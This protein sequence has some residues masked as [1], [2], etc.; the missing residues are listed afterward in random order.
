[1]RNVNDVIKPVVESD[2]EIAAMLQHASIPTLMMSM[3][4][5]S[6]DA[7]ILDGTIRPGLAMLSEVQGY[8]SE[9]DKA[10]VRQQALE[11]IARYRD[12][13]CELPPPPSPETIQRM[14]AFI[15]GE[16]KIDDI[17]L[18]MMQE[19]MALSGRDDRDV[20]ISPEALV[21]R[22]D[23]FHVVVAGGGMSGIL[24][25]V[26]LAQSGIPFTILEKNPDV[27]GTWYENHYPG[28]R[29]DI[30]NHLYSYSFEPGYEWPKFFAER[31]HLLRYFQR[32]AKKHGVSERIRFNSE[33]VSAVYDEDGGKWLVEYDCD[34]EKKELSGDVFVSAVGQL[35][36]PKIPQVKG[37]DAFEGRQCHSAQWDSSLDFAGKNVALVGSG[38]SAFQLA[39]ELAKL[40]CQL[41]VF[42]RT[43]PWMLPN[44]QYHD[45]IAEGKQW[46]LT[47]LP[48]YQR[49]YR[50]LLFWPGADG[51]YPTIHI[52]PDWEDNG[53]SINAANKMLRDMLTA[54]IQE[55]IQSSPEL[56]AHVVPPYP[57][58]A[59]RMLQ[60]NGSWLGALQRD[61]VELVPSGVAELTPQ[62]I[63]SEAGDHYDADIIVWATGFHATRF[64]WPMKVI[65]KGGVAL[66]DRWGDEPKT[67]LGITTPEFP[68]MFCLYGPGTNL[69]HG[70]SIIFHSECQVRYVMSAIK[71]LLEKDLRS[72]ECKPEVCDE[73]HQKLTRLLETTVWSCPGVSSW[74]RNK[75]GR[76][77]TTSPW[78]LADYWK[79]T[80][81]LNIADYQQR[82]IDAT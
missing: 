82:A 58:M 75:E 47:H 60:D 41:K 78:L 45:A 7:S 72:L 65:G 32:I 4:H 57:P 14:M 68:N 64:L 16:E 66:S 76:V 35:N 1:M 9:E 71:L 50:F 37:L 67:Y 19:E 11:V 62:G 3:V 61:N 34:G 56:E 46:C 26:R 51:S 39:P 18:G 23:D 70:G 22:G 77:V 25:G 33:I 69:A 81:E 42:Q 53:L 55:Q 30:A 6:G 52:D 31:E 29:V 20:E 54:Y 21:K 10:A 80:R 36:R 63:I 2:A 12:G 74:Y 40:D 79:W 48:F 73:Y 5:M 43:A 59:T 17:Y 13:G 24:I 27:G 44:P 38:A 49:W 8:M 15:V 28:C